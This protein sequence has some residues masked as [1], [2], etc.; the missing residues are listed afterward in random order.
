MNYILGSIITLGAFLIGFW[1]GRGILDKEQ[2][3]VIEDLVDKALG[4]DVKPGVIMRPTQNDLNDRLNPKI[5]EG[6]KEFKKLLD[7]LP[8]KK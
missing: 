2:P 4:R 6:K 5:A 3:K 8:I 7:T 1:L